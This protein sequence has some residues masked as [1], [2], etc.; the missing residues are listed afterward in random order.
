MLPNAGIINVALSDIFVRKQDLVSG[1]C[2]LLTSRK[3]ASVA[4]KTPDTM[5][6][7]ATAAEAI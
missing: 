5:G 6:E 1:F 2:D 4:A 3:G 7:L